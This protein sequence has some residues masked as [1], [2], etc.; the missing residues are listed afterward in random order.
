MTLFISSQT[1]FR[2]TDVS[3]EDIIT[4]SFSRWHCRASVLENCGGQAS[5][6]WNFSLQCSLLPGRKGESKRR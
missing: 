3:T 2:N 5:L 6:G 4:N 1:C